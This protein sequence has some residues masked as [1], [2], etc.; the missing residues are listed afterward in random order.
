MLR[1]VDQRADLRLH[2]RGI[3]DESDHR[4]GFGIGIPVFVQLHPFRIFILIQVVEQHIPDHPGR[5]RI[6]TAVG[7]ELNRVSIQLLVVFAFNAE[8]E[9]VIQY[10]I[11]VNQV[12]EHHRPFRIL[13]GSGDGQHRAL[14]ALRAYLHRQ[15]GFDN[16]RF[17]GQTRPVVG[18]GRVHIAVDEPGFAAFHSILQ[19][20]FVRGTI[21]VD[22]SGFVP[23]AD[24]LQPFQDFRS[25]V[26]V[27]YLHRLVIQQGRNFIAAVEVLAFRIRCEP[28]QTVRMVHEQG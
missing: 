22:V 7:N 14:Q 17:L 24:Q 8:G 11:G 5:D 6:V 2:L 28:V 15:E 3:K 16:H 25:I 20:C 9:Q 1:N 21:L 27:E 4:R 19:L 13:G 23:F 10:W 12:D 18:G 26:F